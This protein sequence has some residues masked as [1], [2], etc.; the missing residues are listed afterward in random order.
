MVAASRWEARR[1]RR[2]QEWPEDRAGGMAF[3]AVALRFG[4]GKCQYRAVRVDVILDA[5][6]AVLAADS[7]QMAGGKG[8]AQ[9]AA[10]RFERK[11]GMVTLWLV[12]NSAWE[13][14]AVKMLLGE[15]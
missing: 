13:L 2:R 1:L 9:C 12:W 5:S 7:F 14:L 15:S 10:G 4:S 8:W 11:H 3:P 6:V